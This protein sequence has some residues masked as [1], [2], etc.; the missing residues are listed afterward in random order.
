MLDFDKILA[1]LTYRE[2]TKE[3]FSDLLKT[4]LD[5]NSNLVTKTDKFKVYE[6]IAQHSLCT[7]QMILDMV[8][9]LQHSHTNSSDVSKL[10][11]YL[12]QDTFDELWDSNEMQQ[13][14]VYLTLVHSKHTTSEQLKMVYDKH[15]KSKNK[16]V[17]HKWQKDLKSSI[18]SHPNCPSSILIPN[19]KG[20]D[21]AKDM[22][23]NP[24]LPDN[25]LKI[26]GKLSL[27]DATLLRLI[28][29]NLSLDWTKIA[30]AVEMGIQLQRL[31]DGNMHPQTKQIL[32]DFFKRDDATEKGRATMFKLTGDEFFLPQSAKDIFLF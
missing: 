15:V 26:I 24:N 25:V 19:A 21:N 5:S 4:I 11:D 30:Y 9:N 23:S 2:F 17:S 7:E 8:K 31:R 22:A 3:E 18:L 32:I 14:N 29:E 20:V 28:M 27:H 6:K 13:H 10:A 16:T 1:E 12:S